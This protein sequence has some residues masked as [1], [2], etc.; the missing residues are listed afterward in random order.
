MQKR[1]HP[2]VNLSKRIYPHVHNMDGFYV[3]KLKKFANGEKSQEAISNA[4]EE[5]DLKQ[6]E[7]AKKQKLNQKKKAQKQKKYEEKK[8]EEKEKA[9][10]KA[11]DNAPK[12]EK[13]RDKKAE[14]KKQEQK[15]KA[16]EAPK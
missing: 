5:L 12:N 6:K 11:D 13:K 15:K 9:E 4:K 3:C 2:S 10:K 8:N 16:E 1:F 14:A 7:K